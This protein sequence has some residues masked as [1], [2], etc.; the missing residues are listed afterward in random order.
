MA[1]RKAKAKL[2]EREWEEVFRARCRSKEGRSSQ[3]DH[4]LC[5]RAY[6]EDEARYGAMQ[7][8]VFDA[9]VPAGST[10]RWKDFQGRKKT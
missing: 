5:T 1:R 8:D 6:E 2:T 9:T 4:E 3:A 10:V 7:G